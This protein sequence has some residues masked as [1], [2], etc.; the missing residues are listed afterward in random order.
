VN[1]VSLDALNGKF[2]ITIVLRGDATPL[3]LEERRERNTKNQSTTILST[4]TVPTIQLSNLAVRAYFDPPRIY[5]G[6]RRR[7]GYN[8]K[9]QGG[10]A[11]GGEV[12]SSSSEYSYFPLQL[13]P[14]SSVI[15]DTTYFDI[16][17]RIGMGGTSGTRFV[18]ASTDKDEADEYEALLK[19]PYVK[20]YKIV[21]I[22]GL[23]L[24]ASLNVAFPDKLLLGRLCTLRFAAI[25]A[26]WSMWRLVLG[27]IFR[28][29][30]GTLSVMSG[31][32]ML[33]IIFSSG[34]IERGSK[35]RRENRGEGE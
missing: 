31:M 20:K 7:R 2:R 4:T 14:A 22:L 23:I 35:S 12:H 29:A 24:A 8:R 15:L 30:G 3:T 27:T 21:G 13:G 1:V 28:L 18:F 25:T 32:A 6:K 9:R 5:F 26:R 33:A 34:G 16:A 10:V 11:S 19:L 17:V